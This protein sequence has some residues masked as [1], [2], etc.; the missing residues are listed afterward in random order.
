MRIAIFFALALM[1]SACSLSSVK[2]YQGKELSRADVAIVSPVGRYPE[3]E[4]M[5]WVGKIDGETYNLSRAAELQLLSGTHLVN[6]YVQNQ[7]HC[8]ATLVGLGCRWRDA[9][10]QVT[11]RAEKGH[12]YIPDAQV[13]GNT[14][15]VFFNDVGM[16]FPHDCMP[17]MKMVN[18]EAGSRGL[19]GIYSDGGKCE[20]AKQTIPTDGSLITTF[21]IP[22]S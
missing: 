13:M 21:P 4:L 22:G 1:C 17:M 18:G 5:L 20:E 2:T 6:V 14:V 9:H 10:V 7:L 11:L 19:A 16:N 3:R 15:R 12:S 8:G